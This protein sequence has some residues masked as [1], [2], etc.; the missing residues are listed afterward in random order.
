MITYSS[1]NHAQGVAYSARLL[2]ARAVIVMPG[3]APKVK[4]DADLG[5][6]RGDCDRGQRER[7]AAR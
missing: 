2:G 1:G 4:I 6:W 7:G 3:T 5:A